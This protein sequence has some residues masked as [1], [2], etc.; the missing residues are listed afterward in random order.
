MAIEPH[1]GPLEVDVEDGQVVIEGS[2]GVA[3]TLTAQTAADTS[4]EILKQTVLAIG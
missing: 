1:D 2:P 4:D 3:V